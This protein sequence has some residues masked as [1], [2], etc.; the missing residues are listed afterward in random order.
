MVV[1]I[2]LE[3]EV[4]TNLKVDR[5]DSEAIFVE[6]FVPVVVLAFVV[7]IRVVKTKLFVVE[8]LN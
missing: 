6:T 1:E 5:E 2:L 4:I 3:I 8:V 7:V